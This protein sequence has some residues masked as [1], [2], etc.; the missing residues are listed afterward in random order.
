MVGLCSHPVCLLD[1]ITSLQ[2]EGVEYRGF[3]GDLGYGSKGQCFEGEVA[4]ELEGVDDWVDR[5]KILLNF[6]RVSD[7]L[8]RQTCWLG[9]GRGSGKGCVG[10]EG[11]SPFGGEQGGGGEQAREVVFSE[12]P[13]Y[14]QRTLTEQMSF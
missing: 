5:N 6:V 8:C 10:E 12:A 1:A 3:A 14:F 13:G 4:S 2:Q 11:C 7:I 9:E